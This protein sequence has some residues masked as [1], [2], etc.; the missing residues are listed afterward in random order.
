MSPVGSN[1]FKI[2][3]KYLHPP[4]HEKKMFD[5][6][7]RCRVRIGL[8]PAGLCGAVGGGVLGTGFVGANSIRPN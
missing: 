3:R 1:L 7:L 6:E 2:P 8:R 5:V 4:F